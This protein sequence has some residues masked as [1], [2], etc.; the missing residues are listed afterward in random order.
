[1]D[2][3][4]DKIKNE[5]QKHLW[6]ID[7]AVERYKPFDVYIIERSAVFN[8]LVLETGMGMVAQKIPIWN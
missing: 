3:K 7:S 8:I 4:M 6:M 5:T 1:M 2:F